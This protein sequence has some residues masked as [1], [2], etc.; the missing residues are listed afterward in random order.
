MIHYVV[1]PKV[2]KA[3]TLSIAVLGLSSK[4]SFTKAKKQLILVTAVGISD[5]KR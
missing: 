1:P 2:A 4:H 3:S 5:Y